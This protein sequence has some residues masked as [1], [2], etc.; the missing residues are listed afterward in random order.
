METSTAIEATSAT[1]T[2]P[3]KLWYA[4][5]TKALDI[6]S[7]LETALAD[8]LLLELESLYFGT[9]GDPP[10]YM[11]NRDR[12]CAIH[13]ALN[14][15]NAI[16]PRFRPIRRA[17]SVLSLSEADKTMTNDLQVIDLHWLACRGFKTHHKDWKTMFSP[18]FR[19]D[20]AEKFANTVGNGTNKVL[21]LGI[22]K[23]REW[24]LAIIQS[25]EVRNRWQAFN[26]RRQ[27]EYLAVSNA[28]LK[29][30]RIQEHLIPDRFRCYEALVLACWHRTEAA[31][32]Y[33]LMT[34]K[35]TTQ[36]V[37]SQRVKL[38]QTCMLVPVEK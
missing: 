7:E 37:M 26:R 21:A 9:A 27:E 14:S 8:D 29:R 25:P 4:F 20:R 35:A 28:L 30:P 6:T 3:P 36:Q 19:F 11:G 18:V 2:K 24:A 17:K 23:D 13:L 5:S 12:I 33:R 34:G 16:S 1:I 31:N 22:T 15:K 38:F 10:P 32:I